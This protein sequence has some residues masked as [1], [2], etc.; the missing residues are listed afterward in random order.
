MDR[1]VRRQLTTEE[2]RIWSFPKTESAVSSFLFTVIFALLGLGTVFGV[3]FAVAVML[4]GGFLKLTSKDYDPKFVSAASLFVALA[5][6]LAAI[7]ILVNI[8]RSSKKVEREDEKKLEQFFDITRYKAVGAVKLITSDEVEEKNRGEDAGLNDSEFSS[9]FIDI[10]EKR[11]IFLE[12]YHCIELGTESTKVADNRPAPDEFDIFREPNGDLFG[13]IVG[14]KCLNSIPRKEKDAFDY[15]PE[16]GTILAG[17]LLTLH[18]DLKQHAG[19][20]QS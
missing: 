10:G 7:V 4:I 1:T 19:A 6:L 16:S 17:S 15:L 8:F 14:E 12:E 13:A 9:Y 11:I 18:D 3:V 20:A 2:K 5:A